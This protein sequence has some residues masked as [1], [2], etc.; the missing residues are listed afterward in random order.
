MLLLVTKGNLRHRIAK[1]GIE[2]PSET[3]SEDQRHL[4]RV[5]EA[6]FFDDEAEVGGAE[7]PKERPAWAGGA[8]V[9]L[10][11]AD[12]LVARDEVKKDGVTLQSKHILVSS[13]IFPVLKKGAGI[14]TTRHWSGRIS[15]CSGWR[16]PGE[17]GTW[18]TCSLQG[19]ALRSKLL[20]CRDCLECG[21]WI[22]CACGL[23]IGAI[24][25]ISICHLGCGCNE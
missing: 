13:D 14:T 21:Y 16:H 10:N 6:Q 5:A 22:H 19:A 11:E 17:A 25:E 20:W 4:K 18:E 15:N 1:L 3:L 7:Q 23:A 24:E 12:V 2:A 9:Y 8:F